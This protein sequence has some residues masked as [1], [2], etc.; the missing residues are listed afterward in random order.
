[1]ASQ[2]L[3]VKVL[4]KVYSLITNYNHSNNGASNQIL[5]PLTTIIKLAI[6]SFKPVGTKI[7]IDSNK[8]YIQSPNYAQSI[9]RWWYGN[10]REELH[11]ILK[12]ILRAIDNYEPSK[13]VELKNIY[14]FSVK[15]L[16]LL[17][18]SYDN[19][20]SVLCHALDLYISLLENK[21]NEHNLQIESKRFMTN[22]KNNLNLSQNTK[23]NLDKLF[24]KIWNEDDITLISN[25]LNLASNNK[26]EEKNY[27]KSIESIL[28]SKEKITNQIIKDT[29]NLL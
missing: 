1:M 2:M 4:K 5:E 29:S 15:G 24:I 26:S 13:N 11:Y 21:L 17:K 27:L 25:M 23:V 9:S 14:E 18:N 12:P 16:K 20:N 22:I 10:N 6:I 3:D 19:T 7:A 8:I 28:D